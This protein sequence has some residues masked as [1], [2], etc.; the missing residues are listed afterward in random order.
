MIHIVTDGKFAGYLVLSDTV[1]TESAGMIAQLKE[2]NVQPVLL[3]GDHENA[4]AA[5]A[6]QLQ[7]TEVHTNCPP[8]REMRVIGVCS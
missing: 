4:A 6:S 3:T 5:I 1:R 2:L 7:M 8:Q